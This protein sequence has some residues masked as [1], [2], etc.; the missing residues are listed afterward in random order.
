[1]FNEVNDSIKKNNNLFEMFFI[2]GN[3]LFFFY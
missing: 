3:D 2:G 1:M